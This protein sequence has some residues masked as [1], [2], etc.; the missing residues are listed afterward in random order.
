MS[1]A[2]TPLHLAL[3][4]VPGLDVERAQAAVGGRMEVLQR[5]LQ[6]FVDTHGADGP[7]LSRLRREHDAAQAAALA[8]RMRGAASTLG[9]VDLQA[10]LAVL[11]GALDGALDG[12]LKG[13]AVTPP[14]AAAAAQV[15]QVLG[16]LLPALRTAL[17]VTPAMPGLALQRAPAT[18]LAD[19]HPLQVL[20]VLE[21][22]RLALLGGLL[23]EDECDALVALARPHLARSETVDTASG[24]SRVNG[25]RTSEGMFFARE[26]NALV[27]RIE[28]RIAALLEW[29]L[30]RGEGLQVLCYRP[31]AEYRPHHDYFDPTHAGAP[32]LLA[33]GGQ[34]V[35]TL[36]MYLATP[37]AG[38]ATRFPET[39]LEIAPVKGNAVF[40][41]YEEPQPATRTLHA[42]APVQEGEKWVA[43][44]WLRRWHF[45]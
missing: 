15:E 35:A 16:E 19:G 39:G 14:A 6:L 28:R 4:A 38:G 29:P 5:L 18:L 37:T 43:T 36:V 33:R 34:R 40:F 10:A 44:K 11:E 3:A 25:A 13:A 7:R 42:G 30:E 26:G 12:A 2:A 41:A 17:A 9:L 31:G 24:S 1:A 8:H 20:A 45:D 21:R 23:R 27:A 32:A 22:P